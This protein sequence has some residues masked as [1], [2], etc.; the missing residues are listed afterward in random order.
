MGSLW[1]LLWL[2]PLDNLNFPMNTGM[3][4]FGYAQDIQAKR[5][6]KPVFCVDLDSQK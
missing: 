5:K 2:R 3:A 1:A 6:W 4:H